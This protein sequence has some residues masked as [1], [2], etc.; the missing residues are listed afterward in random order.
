MA[1]DEGRGFTWVSRGPGVRVTARHLVE[2]TTG[3][4]RA[5][6]GLEFGGPLGAFL[7]WATSGINRRYLGMESAGLK[8]RSEGP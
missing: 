4:S 8:R 5:T 3:G 2:P 1:V 7:A 6:L